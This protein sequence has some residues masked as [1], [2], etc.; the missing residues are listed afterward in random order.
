LDLYD[1]FVVTRTDHYYMCPH[2]YTT[3]DLGGNTIWVPE[4]EEYGGYTDRHLIVGKQNLLAA[5]DII[6]PLINKPYKF[7]YER[8]HNTERFVKS[9]WDGENLTVR[10]CLRS[11][12]TVATQYDTTRWA[13]AEDELP[14]VPGLFVKYPRE[15]LRAQN[16]CLQFH[17]NR[18]HTSIKGGPKYT[19]IR[20]QN[21]D[22]N[23]NI[24][25]RRVG[26][27]LF[28]WNGTTH[29][30]GTRFCREE[31]G[32]RSICPYSAYC[33]SG[34]IPFGGIRRDGGGDDDD[35]QLW[36][37][38]ASSSPKE[39]VW[40]NIGSSGHACMQRGGLDVPDGGKAK[41]ILCC[42]EG[43][44]DRAERMPDIAL[45][46]EFCVAPGVSTNRR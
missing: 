14:Y 12:L 15:L 32:S 19:L 6:S 7:D 25:E 42:H 34:S 36:S 24:D 16:G 11:M 28:T 35:A 13:A 22:V 43:E 18:N 39:T 20:N 29:E 38:V 17:Y 4:G 9:V 33:S 3:C 40:V 44:E 46:P 5:L 23:N 31:A 10:K 37:P 41:F 45:E 21:K 30:E 2:M 27:L 8:H 1:T 26:P